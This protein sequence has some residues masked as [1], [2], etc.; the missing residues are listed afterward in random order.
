[1]IRCLL[2]IFCNSSIIR[3]HFIKPWQ[4]QSFYFII[5]KRKKEQ[6]HERERERKLLNHRLNF[7]VAFIY[8]HTWR[9][10]A[11]ILYMRPQKRNN[12]TSKNKNDEQHHN[13]T[14]TRIDTKY[15]QSM[16]EREAKKKEIYK[17]KLYF[18]LIFGKVKVRW[19]ILWINEWYIRWAMN[20][21]PILLYSI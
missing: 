3:I 6:K 18:C 9:W 11:R 1:M 5:K 4:T 15:T 17:Q 19:N 8:W 2:T 21:D 12:R 16:S 14:S 20:D 13:L 10:T 7:M